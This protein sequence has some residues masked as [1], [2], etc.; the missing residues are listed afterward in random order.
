MFSVVIP[1]YNKSHIIDRT[2]VSVLTQT[3][4]DFELIIVNDGS[5]D[6]SLNIIQKYLT[7]PRIKIVNQVN[8]GV[9][10]ARNNGVSVA[11]FDYIAFLDGDD[12]WLPGYLAKVKEAIELYPNAGMFGCTSWHRNIVTGKSKNATLN[13]YRGKIQQIEFFENPHIMPHTSAIVVSKFFFNL[14]F[15]NGEGFPIGMKCCED[16][17]CFNRMAFRAPLVYIGF[18]LGIRNS[19]VFG[20][21]TMLSNEERFKLLVYVVNF[22]NLTYNSWFNL[23]EKNVFYITFL[24]YDLRGRFMS[25][26]RIN[27]YKTINYILSGLDNDI[28]GLFPEFELNFYKKKKLNFIA[29]CY[30][31]FTKLNWRRKGYPIVG[32]S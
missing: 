6:N 5:T 24:K 2:I 7:D 12:E 11:T 13:R 26:L 20:Q 23:K 17:C 1:L 3:I 22:Y 30:I 4:T 14:T 10:V 8:Q 27:D 19:G 9:S 15:K 21:I 31:Y 16:L 25:A 32:H 29:K 28:V 18:P